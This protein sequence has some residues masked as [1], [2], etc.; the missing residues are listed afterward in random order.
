MATNLPSSTRLDGVDILR[1]LSILLVLMNHVH[2]RLF[3]ARV[4]YTQGWPDQ[5]V[6]A[7]VWNGQPA[8]QIF[9]TISGFL[10]TTTAL[11][12]WGNLAN[13]SIP[14]FYRLRFARI[15]PLLIL[16]LIILSTLHLARIPNFV[17]SENTGGL[18]R[19]LLAAL[20]FHINVLEA[21]RGY[22][23]ANWDILWS[24]SVEE[25]FYAFFP[26]L[27]WTLGRTKAL[28]AALLLFAALGPYARAVLAQGNEVWREYSYLGGMDAI[29]LGC[30]TAMYIRQTRPALTNL[31]IA[32][33]ALTLCLRPKHLA[34][35]GL[36]MTLL[37]IGTCLILAAAAQSQWRSPAALLPLVKLG[38]RSYEIYL[39]HM[40]VIFALFRTFVDAGKPIHW[41]PILYLGSILIAALLG[42]VVARF[43]SEPMNRRLRATNTTRIS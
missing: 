21:N 7:L 28:T 22:L 30:L 20:T 4:P 6:S 23:P 13:I 1:G 39:T 2:M 36:D 31:G 16:L 42:E 32:L 40:F 12:R 35:I 8:V 29:A 24:L 15:A 5:L 9:F 38:Q 37:S 10:I 33:L 43:Y 3:I 41:V 18:P 25:V 14:G 27:C 17:V 26:I 19:A 34:A 11:R